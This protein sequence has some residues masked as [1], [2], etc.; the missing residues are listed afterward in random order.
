MIKN[1][2]SSIKAKSYARTHLRNIKRH[3]S[4][5]KFSE[6]AGLDSIKLYRETRTLEIPCESEMLNYSYAAHGNLR[7]QLWNM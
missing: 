2:L 3:N 5:D 7:A 1:Y 4:H 6:Q